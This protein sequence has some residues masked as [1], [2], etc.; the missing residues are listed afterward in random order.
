[1]IDLQSIQQ[2]AFASSGPHLGVDVQTAGSAEI[3]TAEE[4]QWSTH[5]ADGAAE[6]RRRAAE[7]RSED[8]D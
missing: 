5:S 2:A 3:P 8:E 4:A 1:V 7:L 6:L